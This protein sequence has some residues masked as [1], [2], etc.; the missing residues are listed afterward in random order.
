MAAAQVGQHNEKRQSY[1]HSLA[2]DSWGELLADA[3]G[4]DG[5]GMVDT[6]TNHPSSTSS[7]SDES[8]VSPVRVPSIITTDID[9]EHLK[10]MRER[11][12]IQQHRDNSNFS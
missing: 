5:P 10:S 2:Y 3:G 7:Q 6:I 12:P 11:M 4:Y 1:G 8:V 9:L